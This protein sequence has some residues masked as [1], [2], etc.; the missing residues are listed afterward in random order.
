[1]GYR[2]DGACEWRDGDAVAAPAEVLLGSRDSGLRR[3]DD[4]TAEALGGLLAAQ[5][6]PC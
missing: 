6:K 5:N 1:M 2:H 3:N 4:G